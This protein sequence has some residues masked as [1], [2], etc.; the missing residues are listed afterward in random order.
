M[1]HFTLLCLTAVLETMSE[2]LNRGVFIHTRTDGK[3]FNL[4]WLCAHTK[5][6]EMCIRELLYADDSTLVANNAVDMRQI[7]DRFSSAA[8]MF[9]LKINISKT[10]LLYQPPPMSIE[11]PEMITV[12]DELLKTTESFTFLGS[13]VTNSNFADLEVERRIQSA[14]KAYGALQ[15]RLELS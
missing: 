12:Y 5:T 11:L 6:L 9:G 1:H 13:T 10:K 2:R 15:K 8:V 14:T 3:L 7:V 4:A